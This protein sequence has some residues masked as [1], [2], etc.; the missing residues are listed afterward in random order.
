MTAANPLLPERRPIARRDLA[1]LLAAE[2][3][4]A[5]YGS[6]LPGTEIEPGRGDAHRAACLEALALH[7]AT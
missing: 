1:V 6:R 4:G 3:A 5:L 2:G 7:Q